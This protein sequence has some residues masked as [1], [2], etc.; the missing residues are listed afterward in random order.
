[1]RH[2]A[3]MI[4][5]IFGVGA[6]SLFVAMP[7]YA[8][9]IPSLEQLRNPSSLGATDSSAVDEESQIRLDMVSEAALSLGLRSGVAAA[10]KEIIDG[11]KSRQMQLD[12][13][14]QFAVM[15]TESGVYIPPVIQQ[16]KDQMTTDGVVM[17]F[18]GVQYKIIKPGR[19]AFNPPSWRDYLFVGLSPE[20]PE[21]P[22]AIL[23]PKTPKEQAIW[24]AG[25]GKGYEMGRK[26]AYEAYRINTNRLDRDYM[27]I[28]LYDSLR[29]RG[30]IT[31][32]V[33]AQS[34]TVVSGDSETLNMNERVLQV[35]QDPAMV[36][37]QSK[38]KPV[39]KSGGLK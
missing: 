23:F 19:L 31:P 32:E 33:V 39:I 26:Q 37:D 25:V 27:G 11:V 16:T 30:L 2:T 13:I 8:Q 36:I 22:N 14:Y 24:D 17:R 28:A 35:T 15:F 4:K 34:Q 1:M 5:R 20:P 7:V 29:Q 38:H 6:V 21:L 10:S 3:T 12:R 9:G 18:L